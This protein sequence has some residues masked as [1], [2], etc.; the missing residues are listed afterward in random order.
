[1]IP[2]FP[3][4]NPGNQFRKPP[5]ANIPYHQPRELPNASSSL[6]MGIL[7]IIGALCLGVPGIAL[8]V[9]AM[10]MGGNA[11][12][13][14]ENNPGAFRESDIRNAKAGKVCALT[15]TLLGALILLFIICLAITREDPFHSF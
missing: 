9:I 6:V 7:S 4:D 5:G 2:P 12:K 8:G 11:V 1:M 10:I 13:N 3:P 14:A 15:G